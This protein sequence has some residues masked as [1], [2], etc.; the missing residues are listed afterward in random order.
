M[1]GKTVPLYRTDTGRTDTGRQSR[2]RF[3]QCSLMAGGAGLTL[4][5]VLR[6]RAEAAISSKPRRDTAVIQ[7]WLGGGPSQF[8]TFD[9]KPAAPVEFRGP[10]SSISTKLPGIRFCETMPKTGQVIDRA[11]IIRTVTHTTNG[12]FVGAHWLSTGYEGTGGRA[13]HPSSGAIASRFRGPIHPGL[14]AYVL[15]SHEFTRNPEIAE[16]MG[17]GHLSVSHAPFVLRQDPFRDEFEF[18]KVRAATANLKLADDVT[19]ERA[20]DRKSLLGELDRIARNIDHSGALAGIDEFNQ[21][22]LQMVTSGEARRAFD[23]N[24]EP[25]ATREKYGM[26]RWGQMGLL[27]R[28]LVE[29]G[30]TFVTLNTA[31]DSLCWDWHL[32]IKN[33][34]RPADGSLGPSRGM[35]VSGPALDQMLSALI[36]D[37]YERG[38]DRKV[39]LIVWGEFGR[40]PRVNKTGGRDHWGALMSILMAGGG[41]QVGQVIGTSSRKGEVPASRPVNPND[42][43]ATIYRHLDIDPTL[44][45]VTREGRPIPVLPDGQP[46]REL[47]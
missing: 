14:P 4:A 47:L 28:R 26:H 44:H 22:A 16:V 43:L 33:D 7:I 30:V 21:T 18:A 19:I 15:L 20:T 40:T 3:V 6:L 17:T 29:A 45:T 42:V 11:A 24:R 23:L 9:P 38:I 46:I 13:T 37:L 35:D 27:A 5:D 39:L 10:Y 8:E 34:K 12:H 2:R 31:P 36:T 32:N 41:L 1:A 25:R